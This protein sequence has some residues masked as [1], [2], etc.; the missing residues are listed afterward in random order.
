MISFELKGDS[1]IIEM[2][3]FMPNIIEYVN[4]AGVLK[5]FKLKVYING[6]RSRKKIQVM[7]NGWKFVRPL[8]MTKDDILTYT[9]E[10]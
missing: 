8:K 4:T 9:W 7:D 1:K 5:K 6:K 3:I 10:I 2:G